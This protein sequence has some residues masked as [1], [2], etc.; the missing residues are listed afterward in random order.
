MTKE[1][2]M[3]SDAIYCFDRGSVRFAIYPQG[4][5]G[6]RV[7]AEIS[8]DALRDV[9]GARGGGD[10]LVEACV[11]NFERIEKVALQHHR[12]HGA[13]PMMLEISDFSFSC[14]P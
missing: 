6:P 2:S 11:E 10:S 8:E 4:R 1:T 9:F 5:D 7:V 3:T 13:E 14:M 12:A